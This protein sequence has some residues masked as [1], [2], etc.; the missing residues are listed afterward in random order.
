MYA[1][2]LIWWAILIAWLSV[3][4]LASYFAIGPHFPNRGATPIAGATIPWGSPEHRRELAEYRRICLA[5]GKSLVWWHVIHW[6]GIIGMPW[7]VVGVVLSL[8]ATR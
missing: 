8:W 7:L 3:A 5:E 4:T 6:Y 1:F 2:L